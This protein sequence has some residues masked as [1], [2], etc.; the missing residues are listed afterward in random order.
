MLSGFA[1]DNDGSILWQ[2]ND[3][4]QARPVLWILNTAGIELNL[5][6]LNSNINT[7]FRLIRLK[8]G[9]LVACTSREV[10]KFRTDGRLIWAITPAF[11][12]RSKDI[13][14]ILA[15]QDG[16]LVVLGYGINPVLN[17]TELLK[18]DTDGKVKWSERVTED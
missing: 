9:N 15:T 2:L 8:D 12:R 4:V 17:E 11:S 5:I 6:N 10:I 13:S 7:F 16:G 18:L 3:K 1:E 14:N